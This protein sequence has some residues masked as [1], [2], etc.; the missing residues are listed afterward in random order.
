MA[1]IEQLEARAA[2]L[3]RQALPEACRPNAV[4]T[5]P[6]HQRGRLNAR[7]LRD[8]A[9]GVDRGAQGCKSAAAGCWRVE[10]VVVAVNTRRGH[11]RGG[12]EHRLL[13]MASEEPAPPELLQ[14]QT[15]YEGQQRQLSVAACAALVAKRVDQHEPRYE[16][17]VARSQRERHGAAERVSD[18]RGGTQLEP[19]VQVGNGFREGVDAVREAAWRR[20]LAGAEPG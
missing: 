19:R 9:A 7:G 18:Y 12:P 3:A 13:E 17:G 2:D 20:L 5:A 4:M 6:D 1:G 10:S 11:A 15:A 16:L 14:H 8:H